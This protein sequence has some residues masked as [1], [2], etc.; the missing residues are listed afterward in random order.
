MEKCSNRISIMSSKQFDVENQLFQC[1]LYSL[2][3]ATRHDFDSGLV[4][5]N[6]LW[7]RLRQL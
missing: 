5:N 6:P 1:L 4:S 2:P 7:L 3:K